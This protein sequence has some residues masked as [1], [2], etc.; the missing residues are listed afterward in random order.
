MQIISI[1]LSIFVFVIYI[2][3]I[4][5]KYGIQDSISASYYCLPLNRQFLF[6]A[7]C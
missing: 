2:E 1:I 5:K 3:Y 7:F 4:I 6:T